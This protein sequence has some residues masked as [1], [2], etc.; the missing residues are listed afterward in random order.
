[1]M[2]NNRL[3]VYS[4]GWVFAYNF[5]AIWLDKVIDKFIEFQK[6]NYILVSSYLNNS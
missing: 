2:I 4:C 5:T 3:Q 6:I 1:M